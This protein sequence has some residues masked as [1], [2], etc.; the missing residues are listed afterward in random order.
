MSATETRPGNLMQGSGLELA[1]AI[2]S[3][4]TSSREVVNAHIALAQKVNPRVNAIV[5]ERYEAARQ[6]A[7]AA[8][9]RVAAAAE[10]EDLPPFLG[11]PCT[12]KE[13][14]AVTGMPNCAGL[15]RLRDHRAT[16][17]ATIVARI[18]EAGAIPLGVTNLS[19]MTMWIES[20]NRLYGLTR[21]AYDPART[22]G[23]SSGGE[24]AAVGSGMSPFGLGSDIGGSI[25]LPAFFNG[26]FGHKNS[27]GLVP[28]TGH[29][30]EADGNSFLL[31]G[32]G[33]LARRAEDLMPV[34][35]AIAGPDGRDDRVVPMELG[36]PGDVDLDGLSVVL[37]EDTSYVPASREL[38]AARERAAAA[39]AEQGAAVRRESLRSVRR[40][41]EYYIATLSS[42]STADL[43]GMIFGEGPRP[44]LGRVAAGTPRRAGEHTWPMVLM[45]IGEALQGRLPKGRLSRAVEAG[46]ALKKEL[47]DVIGDG[48]LLHPP[49][50]RVAPRHG[51]TVG[52]YWLLT[53]PGLFNL[54]GLPATVV[55]LG[56]GR[57]GL[58]L[59]VQVAA[60][61]G[62]DHVTIAVA[63]ALERSLGGWVPPRPI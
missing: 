40:A 50:A 37:S 55:P 43:G 12:V 5:A 56:L 8:D 46:R 4:E 25:R 34:L 3:G 32:L 62:R 52:R 20:R 35:K 17:D 27:A 48:V 42:S 18:R 10:D 61:H 58:P 36:E 26:V 49:F 41:L 28:A 63:Q 13:S 44:R 59:G 23:G 21:N 24:G 57:R 51:R 16:E 1:A 22:A 33:P 29:F 38:R 11:V 14:F 7:E 6:E 15:V 39:L 54:T 9:A 31:L 2:R 19:Q 53:N 45:L 30:P 47:T 60:A